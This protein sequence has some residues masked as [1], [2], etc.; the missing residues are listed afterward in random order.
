[1]YLSTEHSSESE[2]RDRENSSDASEHHARDV[3]KIL[4]H[5]QDQLR[6]IRETL[7]EPG[8]AARQK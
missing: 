1:M 7:A 3:G 8:S 5:A 2:T 6:L 4:L